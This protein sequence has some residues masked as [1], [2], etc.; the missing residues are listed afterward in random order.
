MPI[1]DDLTKFQNETLLDGELVVDR[2]ENGQVGCMQSATGRRTEHY[3]LQ[4]RTR[5]LTY[6]LMAFN[7]TNF[8]QRPF[9]MRL[10]VGSTRR[11]ALHT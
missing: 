6:D 1:R 2:E 9:D 4:A 7:G 10:G 11:H 5:Y 8:T 3:F